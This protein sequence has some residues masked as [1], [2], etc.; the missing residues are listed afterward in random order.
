MDGSAGESGTMATEDGT[1]APASR[2]AVGV[3]VT[4]EHAALCL[5]RDQP[6][7]CACRARYTAVE[8]GGCAPP[9]GAR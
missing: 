1:V 9:V 3:R 5:C 7:D 4:G 8:A 6:K 2:A